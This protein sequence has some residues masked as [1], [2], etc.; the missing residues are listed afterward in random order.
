MSQPIALVQSGTKDFAISSL[1]QAIPGELDKK[2]VAYDGLLVYVEFRNN[3]Q[4]MASALGGQI[5]IDQ[6]REIYTG[7]I[8]NWQEISSNL[9]NLK[10]RP[11]APTEP[12]AI[13]KFQEIVLKNDPQDIALFKDKEKVTQLETGK[14]QNKIR[15][16]V[17]ND[18][19]TGII[20]FGIISK[21]KAQCSNYPLAIIDGN[22]PSVQPLFE[23]RENRSIKTSDNLCHHANYFFDVNTFQ[24]YPLGYPIFVVY[25]KDNSRPAAGDAFAQILTTRQ[26]QCLL[27]KV[28]LVPLQP[29]PDDVNKYGCKSLS[30]S[31]V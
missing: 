25:P 31:K 9:P 13:S 8:T 28:G 26:G 10:I 30:E 12:E 11:F 14:T 18:T 23:K 3:N 16:E 24:N 22:K 27:S 4:K 1:T 15:E 6:L 17:R 20:G 19:N 7:R 2:P 29:I 21:V 5:T